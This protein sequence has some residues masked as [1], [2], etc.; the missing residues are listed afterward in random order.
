MWIHQ[1][2]KHT[3]TVLAQLVRK[4]A[5]KTAQL[6]IGLIKQIVGESSYIKIWVVLSFIPTGLD[7]VAHLLH[8]APGYFWAEN[9]I[10]WM[11]AK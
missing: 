6:L 2:Q 9:K 7:L 1:E 10:K 4:Q 8:K 3:V 5:I 11:N